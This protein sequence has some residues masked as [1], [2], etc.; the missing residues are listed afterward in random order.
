MAI[1]LVCNGEGTY[2]IINS[3]GSHLYDIRCP[4]CLGISDEELEREA[5]EA[6]AVFEAAVAKSKTSD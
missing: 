5:A 4:E 2:P 3:K 1:C 6:R